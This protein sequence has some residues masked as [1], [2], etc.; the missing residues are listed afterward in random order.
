MIK[1]IIIVIL[2]CVLIFSGALNYYSFTIPSQLSNIATNAYLA[3]CDDGLD[4]YQEYKN[5]DKNNRIITCNNLSR[6]FHDQFDNFLE[7]INKP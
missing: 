3:G 7:T 2:L 4:E 5:I 6:I 1:N